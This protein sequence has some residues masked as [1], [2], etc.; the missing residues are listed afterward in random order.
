MIP[1]LAGCSFFENLTKPW[2]AGCLQGSTAT[3]GGSGVGFALTAAAAIAAPTP[4]VHSDKASP[5]YLSTAFEE[6]LAILF[7]SGSVALSL[8]M[9]LIPETR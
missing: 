7:M 9:T 6:C 3:D 2:Y 1:G 4:M 5:M 8:A